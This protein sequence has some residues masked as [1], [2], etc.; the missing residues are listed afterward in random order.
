MAVIRGFWELAKGFLWS[1]TEADE[2]RFITQQRA[3]QGWL[4]PVKL[5]G[6]VTAAGE[7]CHPSRSMHPEKCALAQPLMM[8]PRS[9]V[10]LHTGL[11]KRR[12]CNGSLSEHG[13][14]V[15]T[16]FHE[17]HIRGGLRKVRLQHVLTVNR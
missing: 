9:T 4:L 14:H 6:W 10:V 11:Q 3:P 16:G 5:F 7:I 15:R 13:L 8:A 12:H 17:L 2:E 1:L